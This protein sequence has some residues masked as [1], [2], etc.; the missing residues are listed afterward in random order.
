MKFIFK[1]LDDN[2]NE[3]KT[4][5]NP[6]RFSY[7]KIQQDEEEA[8]SAKNYRSIN[9]EEIFSYGSSNSIH[10][11]NVIYNEIED[12]QLQQNTDN[13]IRILV[14]DDEVLVRN[15]LKRY[16][17]R[18]ND[19]GFMKYHL[20]F[21]EAE[22]CF[23][24]I[25][26]IYKGFTQNILF[27]YVMIDEYMPFMKGSTLIKIMTKLHQEN[28]FY[29]INFTSYTSFDTNEKKKFI[30]DQGADHILNKPISYDDY[31]EFI[32]S[33]LSRL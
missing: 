2:E 17:K 15:T 24:A 6:L 18:I 32:L 26:I 20:K 5:D 4:Y 12:E 19:E 27:N 1:I 3:T 13:I 28:N 11:V 7:N 21:Y 33:C 9:G 23:H 10:T 16:L 22:N 8:M 29:K 31:K 30:M 14:V 25:E